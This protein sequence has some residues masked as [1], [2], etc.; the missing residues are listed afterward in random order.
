MRSHKNSPPFSNEVTYFVPPEPPKQ[1]QWLTGGKCIKVG[2][3]VRVLRH[4]WRDKI[5]TYLGKDYAK[6]KLKIR[7]DE[8]GGALLLCYVSELRA[9]EPVEIQD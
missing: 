1:Q 4:G 9:A 6:K 7:F 5:G 3:P 2:D 8:C